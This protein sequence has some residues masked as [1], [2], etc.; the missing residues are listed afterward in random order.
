MYAQCPHCETLFKLRSSELTAADARVRCGM[1]YTVFNALENLRVPTDEEIVMET[2]KIVAEH[3]NVASVRKTSE[4]G[5]D[6]P[7]AL[8]DD[9]ENL[10]APKIHIKKYSTR[11]TLLI[12]AGSLLLILTLVVQFLYFDRQR[13]MRYPEMQPVITALCSVLKCEIPVVRDTRKI[14]LLNRQLYTHPNA[15]SALMINASMVNNAPF[16]QPYPIVELSLSDEQGNIVAARRFKPME[17]LAIDEDP[18]AMMSPGSPVSITLE[19]ADPGEH[20]LAYEFTFL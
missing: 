17:Y 5:R 11:S 3:K 15:E 18:L 13:L 19:I 20:A 14:D 6:V 7:H 4:E 2:N 9:L 16:A 8:Q 1:C 10:H 12:F